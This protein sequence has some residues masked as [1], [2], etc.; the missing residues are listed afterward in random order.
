MKAKSNDDPFLR[1]FGITKK[2][3]HTEVSLDSF[4]TWSGWGDLNPH[5]VAINGF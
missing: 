5:D 4:L 1:L 2:S 3:S